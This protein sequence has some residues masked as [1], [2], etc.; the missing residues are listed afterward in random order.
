MV[1]S[2]IDGVR[3]AVA[4]NDAAAA[5]F[6]KKFIATYAGTAFG[7]LPKAEIDLL[8]FGLL[9]DA[10]AIDPNGSIFRIARA[11]N[12][13]P[14]KARNLLFSYQLRTVSEDDSDYAVMI[15][16]TTARYRK[17]GESLEFGVHSPLTYAAIR[18]KMQ[19]GGVFADV[20]L[21]GDILRVSPDQFGKVLASLITPKQA[22]QLIERLGN[23]KV[24][25]EKSV[26][27]AVE[28]IG[29]ELANR[30]V[31]DGTDDAFTVLGEAISKGTGPG[32][33]LLLAAL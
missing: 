3:S 16:L 27:A 30:A 4:G 28:K 19:D 7:V 29:R 17:V 14:T 20:S 33:A 13:T 15:A 31:K 32:I 11:L 2:T 5:A 1:A 6:G 23:Q 18:A 9:I 26:K 24:V 21:S 10:A 8:V 12:I 25:D 22:R